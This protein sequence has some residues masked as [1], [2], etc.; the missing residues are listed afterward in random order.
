MLGLP[1]ISDNYSFITKLLTIFLHII[2]ITIK[3]KLE[4][5]LWHNHM[6]L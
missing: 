1:N 4:M 5:N 2:Q 3:N 6:M